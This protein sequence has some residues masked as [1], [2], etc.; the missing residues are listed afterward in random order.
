MNV[1]CSREKEMPAGQYQALSAYRR[2]VFVDRL[3]WNL[4]CEAGC[5]QDQFDREDTVYLVARDDDDV[6][7][8]GRLLPSTGPYLLQEVFPELLN[9]LE[10][11][12]SPTVWELSRFAVGGAGKAEL[13]RDKYL[14]TRMLLRALEF[15]QRQ[16][17]QQLLAVTTG[18]VERLMLRAGVDLQRLGPPAII[19]GQPVFAFVIW[20]NTRSIAALAVFEDIVVGRS[21]RPSPLPAGG[22]APA[23]ILPYQLD[24][25][26][27]RNAEIFDH[28][29]FAR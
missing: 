28:P 21:T 17:V 7:G 4:P 6:I 19:D 25:S 12:R 24:E 2:K 8:C 1:I 27:I 29:G 20:V 26:S 23:T 5:E 16:G 15:C 11:P 9:G 10:P 18:A 14:A 3:G 13:A 22:L